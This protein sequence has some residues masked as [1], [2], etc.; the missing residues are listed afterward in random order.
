M[1]EAPR[2]VPLLPSLCALP[3]LPRTYLQTSCPAPPP[4][5]PA[6]II[7]ALGAK[8]IIHN[9]FT[10][11]LMTLVLLF[12]SPLLKVKRRMMMMMMMMCHGNMGYRAPLSAS[13]VFRSSVWSF[14]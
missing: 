1:G 8:T 4:A 9:V 3:P 14:W 5:N 13:P 11:S 2:V 7:D 6:A 10:F 12:L